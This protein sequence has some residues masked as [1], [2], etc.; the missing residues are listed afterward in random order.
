ALG[1]LAHHPDTVFDDAQ[2]FRDRVINDGDAALTDLRD[3]P[4]HR[5]AE[6]TADR[7]SYPIALQIDLP[8]TARHEDAHQ[9]G[10]RVARVH[11]KADRGVHEQLERSIDRGLLFG[12]VKSLRRVELPP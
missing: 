8:A 6:C 9:P 10:K 1:R 2:H 5:A 3:G 4:A 12:H 11:G 7:T